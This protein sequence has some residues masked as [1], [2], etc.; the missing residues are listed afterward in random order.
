MLRGQRFIGK[1][2]RAD[3]RL[4][5]WKS[6]PNDHLVN[7]WC[8]FTSPTEFNVDV[9]PNPQPQLLWDYPPDSCFKP[10]NHQNVICLNSTVW[11]LYI[12]Y[13]NSYFWEDWTSSGGCSE[14]FGFGKGWTEHPCFLCS[15]LNLVLIN[16]VN[17]LVWWWRSGV[18]ETPS[19]KT[20]LYHFD[21]AACLNMDKAPAADI[22]A[23]KWCMC[24]AQGCIHIWNA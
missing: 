8:C 6:D 23:Y 16:A 18:H 4:V 7:I 9:I 3:L 11:T 13:I 19:G 24:A 14:N 1:D 17:S 22:P 21:V 12:L 5:L 15:V 20:S 2:T 10:Q